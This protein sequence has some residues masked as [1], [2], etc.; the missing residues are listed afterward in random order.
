[1]LNDY[2]LGPLSH[3]PK[4]VITILTAALNK[5]DIARELAS[6]VQ[7]LVEQQKKGEVGYCH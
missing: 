7:A 4:Q 5:I 6:L 2:P 3:T 1:M